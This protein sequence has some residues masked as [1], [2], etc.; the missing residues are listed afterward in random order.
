[1]L[2]KE[3]DKNYI[4]KNRDTMRKTRF[5]VSNFDIIQSFIT[6]LDVGL[7]ME[8]VFRVFIFKNPNNVEEFF[9]YYVN[10]EDWYLLFLEGLQIF[11]FYNE[12]DKNKYLQ[13]YYLLCQ[14]CDEMKI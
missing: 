4:P 8:G 14:I 5:I 13:F 2:L 6:T 10:V 11:S 7:E 1:M 9:K 12:K 3:F